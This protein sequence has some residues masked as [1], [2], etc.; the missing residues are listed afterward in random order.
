MRVREL[1]PDTDFVLVRP[2][3]DPVVDQAGYDP[4]SRYVERFW[5]GV[6]GP[7]VTWLLRYLVARLEAEPDGFDLDLNTCATAIGLGRLQG[8]NAAFPRTVARACQ[9]GAGRLLGGGTTLE[10][11]R[12]LPPLTQRQVAR[13]PEALRAE[14]ERWMGGHPPAP[15]GEELRDRARQLAL[16]LLQLGEDR[17]GTERQL[18][19]WRFHPTLVAEATDWALDRH[20][21]SAVPAG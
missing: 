20:A 14:H 1:P 15:S 3:V 16:S 19:R 12:K 2:W 9:F 21:R 17:E 10:V 13:L 5:L 18:Q 6:L 11:R 4:R 8:P 7:S